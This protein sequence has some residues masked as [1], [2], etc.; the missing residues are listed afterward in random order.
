MRTEF[1]GVTYDESRDGE[2]L[3]GQQQRVL[4][5]LLD[6]KKRTLFEIAKEADVPLSTVSSRVRDCRKNEWGKH[7]V[8]K[9]LVSRGTYIYWIPQAPKFDASGQAIMEFNGW[10]A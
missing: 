1:G 5:L 3:Q 9:K 8:L 2:R 10:A 6:G 4:N 7:T